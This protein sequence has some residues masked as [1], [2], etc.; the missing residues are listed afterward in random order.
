MN[1]KIVPL[2]DDLQKAIDVVA[3]RAL[4]VDSD[5][6]QLILADLGPNQDIIAEEDAEEIPAVLALRK[7]P[8]EQWKNIKVSSESIF[9]DKLW[10]FLS[11]PHVDKRSVRLNFD[12]DNQNGINLTRPEYNHWENIVKALIFYNIPHF[13]VSNYAR[14]YGSLGSKRTKFG[15]LIALFQKEQLYMGNLGSPTFRTIN[16][17]NR[18]TIAGYIAGLPTAGIKWEL[19]SAIQLWQ[20]VLTGCLLPDEYSITSPL[21]TKE[22][23]AKLRAEYEDE[24]APFLPIALDDYSNI[25][26]H[27]V[28]LVNVYSKD[29][30]WLYE[31]YYRSIIG[32]WKHSDR[33]T[34][35]PVCY[36]PGSEAGVKAFI[37][38][39][40]VLVDGKPWWSLKIQERANPKGANKSSTSYV[41]LPAILSL[42]VSLLDAC[43][44]TILATTGMRRSEV[45]GLLS[46]CVEEDESGFWLRY[47]VF[48]TSIASQGDAKRI[49]IPALTAK[50]IAIVELICGESRN[51]G[52]HNKLFSSVTRQ[53]FG[54]E[55][56]AA[57]PE[58]AVKRVC[59]AVG[60]DER[61]HPHRFRKT[62]AMYLIYQDSKNIEIIRHLFSH[63]SL[64]M[65]LRYII[66]L[67][68]VNDEMKKIIVEQNLEILVEILE[69]AATGRLGGEAGNRLRKSVEGS[70]R[71]IAKLQDKGREALVQ[72]VES[73]LDEG[74]KMLHRTNLAICMKTPGYYETAPCDGKN[75]DPTT[76]LHP[77]LF[78]CDPFNCR[79][80]AFV[81]ANVPSLKNEILFH[82]KYLA[83]P[84]SSSAQ[85]T[86]SQRR[87]QDAKKRLSEVGVSDGS[88]EMEAA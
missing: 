6:D 62:L 71:L 35:N 20:K 58:R 16:D 36:S 44:V 60:A 81:E 27:C 15:R 13:A 37:D 3:S 82:Q 24:S 45:M 17:L 68:G 63:A 38:Y 72:Y 76:K 50:A 46:G 83:H 56:H 73:M 29:I 5:E 4:E 31:T 53:F 79:F 51:Y 25:V 70:P 86:F 48:K 52:K 66:S 22:Q 61:I 55:T 75:D 47:T 77:N 78:A 88:T 26:N 34:T 80:A 18:E 39:Q 85:K 21:V 67:P 84:L 9:G 10:S 43:C 59:E 30:T 64:K 49:P 2:Q 41:S 8:V 57:Y 33:G 69:G 28:G 1:R 40:P 12:F 54:G 87:I 65:T 32:G 42:I 7:I 23:I 14:S 11:Y 19:A 74:V